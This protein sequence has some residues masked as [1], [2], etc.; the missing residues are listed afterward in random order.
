[1]SEVLIDEWQRYKE[2]KELADKQIAVLEAKLT[3]LRREVVR[4][5]RELASLKTVHA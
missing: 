4:Q 5:D 2:E 3:N 1:M